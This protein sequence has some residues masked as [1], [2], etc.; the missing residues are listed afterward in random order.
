MVVLRCA[1]SRGDFCGVTVN[2]SLREMQVS[3]TVTETR[4]KTDKKGVEEG[5]ANFILQVE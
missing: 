3:E 2:I 1:G 5:A 4:L